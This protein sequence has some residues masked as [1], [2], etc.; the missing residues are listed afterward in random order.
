SQWSKASIA[1]NKTV[2]LAGRHAEALG[3]K[4]ESL[5][6]LGIVEG[7]N[8]ARFGQ[9]RK[10][11]A[12]AL[13]AGLAHPALDRGTALSPLAAGQPEKAIP[14]LVALAT[15]APK[16]GSL[17][18]YLGWAQSAHGDFDAAIKS[19]D[20]AVEIAAVNTHALFGRAGAKEAKGDLEGARADYEALLEVQKDNIA[21]QVGLAATQPAEQAKQQE[22]DLMAIL[23]LKDVDK[24]DP[25]ATLR[26]WNF[27]AELARKRG[28]LDVARERYRKAIALAPANTE[29]LTG[30]ADVELRDNKLDVAQEMIDKALKAA[31]SDLRAALVAVE[32]AIAKK[33]FDIAT[34]K[35]DALAKRTP[36][37]PV[38]DQ[39]RMKSL[40]ARLLMAQG[41]EQDAID[42]Y[43]EAAKLAGAQDLT[44]TL[45]AARVMT[46]LADRATKANDS[47]RASELR[48]KA[49]ELLAALSDAAMKDPRLAL[50]LGMAYLEAGDPTKS[51]TWLR[52]CL[53]MQPKNVDAMYQLAKALLAQAKEAEA[54][55]NLRNAVELDPTR[56]EIGLELARTYEHASP[57]RLDDAE[58]LYDKLIGAKEPTLELRARAGRFFA[59]VGQM[60]KAGEQGAKIL[61]LQEDH[62]AGLYLKGEGLFHANKTD[63]ARKLFV[64][65]SDADPEPQYLDA[66]GRAAERWAAE[67]GNTS[68]QDDAL[69]SF[70][71][72]VERDPQLFSA[73]LGQGRLYV[74]RQ[75]DAKALEPLQKAWQIKQTAEV[76]RLLGIALKNVK[77]QPQ[78]AAG[79]LEK[80]YEM[81]PTADAAFHLGELYTDPRLNNPKA[82]IRSYE[83][84]TSLAR[85]GEKDGKPV[86]AWL[87]Q[88]LYDLGDIHRTQNN[89]KGAKDAWEQWLQRNPKPGPRLKEVQQMMVT[90]LKDL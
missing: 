66:R 86:P 30:L 29:A 32:V 82:A 68:Y 3:I 59:R 11:L 89:L 55:S 48:K 84:A 15:R 74:V 38:V 2:E 80:A 45:V 72:A 14:K 8:P 79:W 18:L 10:S 16:D 35:L 34:S 17:Q 13:E 24:K 60:Q 20:S 31:P 39:A 56:S 53:E 61:E 83:R 5:F 42:A 63:A 41:K 77:N 73:W 64:Q 40:E 76:A 67:S 6:A 7:N 37:P 81:E 90:T 71:R 58:K 62:P 49:D 50:T 78:N 70:G 69:R 44:P 57:P 51:E 36:P 75:E 85:R 4:A 87:A 27:A 23:A 1:A 22:D 9:A 43:L 25:R 33:Q 88:A 54:I 12:D 26:A 19:F 46:E 47:A 28:A 65:A 52:Q 21:A